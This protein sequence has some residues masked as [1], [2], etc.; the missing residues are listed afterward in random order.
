VYLNSDTCA[1]HADKLADRD[2]RIRIT[3]PVGQAAR[4]WR[5]LGQVLSDDEVAETG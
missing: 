5:E 2:T 1:G 3:M 4:L